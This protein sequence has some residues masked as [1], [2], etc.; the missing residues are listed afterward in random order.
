MG[1][2]LWEILL[3]VSPDI[4]LQLTSRSSSQQAVHINHLTNYFFLA[5]AAIM[6]V[7]TSLTIYMMIRF[8]AK[9]EKKSPEKTLSHKWEI[10]MLGIPL[11]MVFYFFY[12]SVTTTAQ[13]TASPTEK[14]A[15]VT[16][17]GHQW[18]WQIDY[19]GQGV[20]TANEIHLPVQKNILLKL[21]SAD[22]I[23]SWWV[24]QLGN[25]IDLVPSHDNYL[26]VLI[27]EPGKYYGRCS[28]FCGDQ[29]AHMLITV[30]A[31]TEAEYNEWLQRHRQPAAATQDVATTG[32]HL[33]MEKTCSNCHRING[34]T[35]GSDDGPDLTHLASRETLLSGMLVNNYSNL[36]NWIRDPQK[37]KP[38]S[39]MPDFALEDSTLK[40]ITDYLSSLK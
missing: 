33:F 32:A 10:A 2:A 13:I 27:K 3:Q 38:G 16:I 30:I 6:L 18:W 20:T 11:L 22:V 5:A 8:H 39:H 21:L 40:A 14:T 36:Y 25:K 9:R 17:T 4:S 28:E 29:H 12:L 7:V 1:N 19:P 23:H 35:A 15:D 24:P 37:I 31:Q 26:S 34:V